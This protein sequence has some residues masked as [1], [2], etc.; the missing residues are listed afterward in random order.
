MNKYRKQQKKKK[1]S[2]S[3]PFFH[4]TIPSEHPLLPHKPSSIVT[5]VATQA[6]NGHHIFF[7]ALP[8]FHRTTIK[9]SHFLRHPRCHK[10][11]QSLEK[12]PGDLRPQH[13]GWQISGKG[14]HSPFSCGRRH[15]V[16]PLVATNMHWGGE[17]VGSEDVQRG[18]QGKSQRRE[19][20]IVGER[21]GKK[22]LLKG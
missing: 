1:D 5:A 3:P 15:G 10:Q 13:G 14:I 16:F 8:W 20:G 19:L 22:G 21:F 17:E 4:R 12:N 11:S 7:H 2:H 6:A 18:A 9:L